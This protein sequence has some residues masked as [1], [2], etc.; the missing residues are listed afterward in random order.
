MGRL[1]QT[2]LCP[3]P[4]NPCLA[5]VRM[6]HQLSQPQSAKWLLMSDKV[7]GLFWTVYVDLL[8]CYLLQSVYSLISVAP[9]HRWATPTLASAEM[10]THRLLAY[11]MGSN[12][13]SDWPIH[14]L[15]LSF[16]DLR[17]IPVRRLSSAVIG[18]MIL[19]AYHDGR[20][21]RT[22][23]CDARIERRSQR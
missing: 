18:S 11:A 3:Q 7:I 13:D 17:G 23:S 21:G 19:A 5:T 2:M 16:H 14:S 22:T 12:D 10:V 15:M 6:N 1:C 20:R 8:V 9:G 4:Q